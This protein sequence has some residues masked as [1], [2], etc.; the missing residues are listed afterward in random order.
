MFLTK[1]SWL[2]LI[3]AIVGDFVVPYVLALFYKGYS[4]KKMV[5]STLGSSVSPVK[6]IYN[7]WLIVLGVLFIYSGMNM[8]YAYQDISSQLSL[9]LSIMMIGYGIG[10]GI[11]A[12]IFSVEETS[13][14][15]TVAS[16]IHGIASGLGF[17]MLLF[18]SLL[19]GLLLLNT[20]E[21]I[22]GIAG[23]VSFIFNIIFFILFILSEKEKFQNTIIG[24]TG[25]WQRILLLSMYGPLF[26]ISI[27]NIVAA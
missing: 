14:M 4:H 13:K 9:A 11:F 3:I 12:G 18:A 23:L 25:L 22:I 5:M 17:M 6:N 16:T 7:C 19:L 26:I 15:G 21:I 20:G 1:I 10:A 27:K 2:L 24:L 8:Y